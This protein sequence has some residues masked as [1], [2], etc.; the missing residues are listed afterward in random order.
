MHEAIPLVTALV[1]VLH[2]LRDL[3]ILLHLQKHELLKEGVL[4]ECC[5]PAEFVDYHFQDVFVSD[6][7]RVFLH[8]LLGVAQDGD[9]RVQ[10]HH[11]HEDQHSHDEDG[12]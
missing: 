5:L 6:T 9:E 10:H 2:L 7:S 4:L 1:I 11:Q 3:L 12:D 8:S